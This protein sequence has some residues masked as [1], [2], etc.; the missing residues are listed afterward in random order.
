[1]K[2]VSRK[3]DHWSLNGARA[4]EGPAKETEDQDRQWD[5]KETGSCAGNHSKEKKIFLE[6]RVIHC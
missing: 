2:Q 4:G 6:G 5:K 1:M 3:T